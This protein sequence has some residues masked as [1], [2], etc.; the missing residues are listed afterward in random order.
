[1][2]HLS[3]LTRGEPVP[4]A[5]G[6]RRLPPGS[7]STASE[8]SSLLLPLSSNSAFSSLTVRWPFQKVSQM[9]CLCSNFS[10]SRSTESKGLQI[11]QHLN[12]PFF[13]GKREIHSIPI[14][15][16]LFPE[17]PLQ[18]RC[19]PYDSHP[20]HT[21]P[22]SGLPPAASI[23]PSRSSQSTE[24]SSRPLAVCSAH[25]SVYMSVLLSQVKNIF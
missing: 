9:P 7:P 8:P 16:C 17:V 5:L 25:A 15:V 23:R 20:V 6:A 13:L 12:P 10:H 3:P 21:S 24:P 14:T 22:P 19:L 2:C 1:M 18:V 11:H 4:P